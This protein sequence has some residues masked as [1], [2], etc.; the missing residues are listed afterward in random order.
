MSNAK[1][2]EAMTRINQTVNVSRCDTGDVDDLGHMIWGCPALEDQRQ[3]QLD[4]F[5][6]GKQSP[7]EFLQ[8]DSH[9]LSLFAMRCAARCKEL[10]GF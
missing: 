9:E 5:L 1:P 6:S 4:L 8:Q 3:Q 2:M 10:E 7:A